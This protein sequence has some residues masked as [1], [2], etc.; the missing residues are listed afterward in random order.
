MEYIFI[1][2]SYRKKNRKPTNNRVNRSHK[3]FARPPGTGR[4]APAGGTEPAVPRGEPHEGT[5]HGLAG[6]AGGGEGPRPPRGP[7][8]PQ[9]CALLG[10]GSRLA[11]VSALGGGAGAQ[12]L[13]GRGASH[14]AHQQSADWERT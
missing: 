7:G 11:G 6:T 3:E 8:E 13:A 4:P 1:E 2:Q 10:D 9:A 5:P 14:R 12:S